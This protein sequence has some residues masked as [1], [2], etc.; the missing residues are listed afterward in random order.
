[1]Y[2]G[3]YSLANVERSITWEK[4]VVGDVFAYGMQVFLFVSLEWQ[5]VFL[6]VARRS[7]RNICRLAQLLLARYLERDLRASGISSGGNKAR[8]ESFLRA[9]EVLSLVLYA[10]TS[11]F[12]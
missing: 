11:P 9:K 10:S 8:A 4:S 3:G 2:L 12:F 6:H 1:L 7:L 5:L